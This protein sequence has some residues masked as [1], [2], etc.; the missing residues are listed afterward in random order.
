MDAVLE[1]DAV[2][3]G[4]ELSLMQRRIAAATPSQWRDAIVLGVDGEG[5]IELAL[6][7]DGR[8]LRVWNH[9]ASEHGFTTGEPV[10]LHGRY[11]VLARGT[12]WLNVLVDSAA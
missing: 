1:C 5:W 12:E 10:V 2:G 6:F 9:R 8:S 7:A 3:A 11:G 4:H